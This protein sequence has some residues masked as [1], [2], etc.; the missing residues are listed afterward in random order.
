MLKAEYMYFINP[1]RAQ[2]ILKSAYSSNNKILKP[3]N[4]VSYKKLER[5]KNQQ[6][7]S[8][9]NETKD[10]ANNEI[11]IKVNA[12]LDRLQFSKDTH[13]QFESEIDNLGKLLGFT[14]QMPEKEFNDGGPDNLWLGEDCFIIIEC[15]NETTTN[16]ISK[17]DIEQLLSSIIW[18]KNNFE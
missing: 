14:T 11:L 15:K 13:V 2:E 12:N 10:L 18:F 16:K 1:V 4:G 17:T 6:V 8:I 7:L 5:Q 3:A 9:M